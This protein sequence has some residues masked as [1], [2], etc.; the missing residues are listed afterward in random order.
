MHD[1]IGDQND[2]STE[3]EATLTASSRRPVRSDRNSPNK[4]EG[5]LTVD[6]YQTD[7]EII[8]KSTIAGITGDDLDIAVT[9]DT[10]TIKG[11]RQFDDGVKSPDYFYQEIYWGPFSRS[12]IL[13][14]EVDSD[15]ARA[16]LKNGLLTLILPKLAKTRTKK[17]KISS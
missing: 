10:V 16:S 1:V 6:V 2:F 14:E 5:I 4:E 7:S 12:I 9:N 17:I 11:R 8:I 3:S 15:A 13:P